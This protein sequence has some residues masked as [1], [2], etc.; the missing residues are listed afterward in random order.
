MGALEEGPPPPP[1]PRP[2]GGALA[3]ALSPSPGRGGAAPPP[4]PPPPPQRGQPG[5]PSPRPG[6]TIGR[7][8]AG[9]RAGA[10]GRGRGFVAAADRGGPV[11]PRRL[12][13]LRKRILRAPCPS[14]GSCPGRGG[15]FWKCPPPRHGE[16][17][18]AG[19]GSRRRLR[20]RGAHPAPR[21]PARSPG[22]AARGA[23][24]TP[25]EAAAVLGLLKTTQVS[26]SIQPV[27]LKLMTG[28]EAG[29]PADDP[30]VSLLSR[31]K[32][33][34][35]VRGHGFLDCQTRGFKSSSR[36]LVAKL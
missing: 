10:G 18:G 13:A 25:E 21:T 32:T 35:E 2:P 1:P 26:Q 4:G 36:F 3:S 19:L 23:P 20:G 22:G 27:S 7:W 11:Q 28:E 33:Q 5:R 15:F 29:C 9:S 31:F 16:G 34:L 24:R 30:Q 17:Y 6:R 8:G 12:R 14:L